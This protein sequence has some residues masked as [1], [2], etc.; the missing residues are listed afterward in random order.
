MSEF[1]EKNAKKQTKQQYLSFFFR[2]P[3]ETR[4]SLKSNFIPPRLV[5]RKCSFGSGSKRTFDT[6]CRLPA[7]NRRLTHALFL[8]NT[9]K[10]LKRTKYQSE[11]VYS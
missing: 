10:F 5:H 4:R 9:N 1:Y 8:L 3:I 6:R 11:M 7:E 2:W